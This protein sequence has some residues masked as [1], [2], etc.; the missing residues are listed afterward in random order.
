MAFIESD[1]IRA[2]LTSLILEST[3]REL[4]FH[5]RKLSLPFPSDPLNLNN[6]FQG[7]QNILKFYYVT[8]Q[9]ILFQQQNKFVYM[10]VYTNICICIYMSAGRWEKGFMDSVYLPIIS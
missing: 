4:T 3:Q 1:L 8:K 7:F 2:P 6:R 10:Y 5:I 9:H